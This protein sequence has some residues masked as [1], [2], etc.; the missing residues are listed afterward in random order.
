MKERTKRKSVFL[1][2]CL[3]LLIM[4]AM[5]LTACNTKSVDNSTANGDTQGKNESVQN[6]DDSSSDGTTDDATQ[7]EDENVTDDAT[8][9]EESEESG[10]GTTDKD[11]NP[12]EE[13]TD[14]NVT[15][16]D[17]TTVGGDDGETTD[18]EK[19]TD[20]TTEK[21]TDTKE[22]PESTT[23][24]NSGPNKDDINTSG[25]GQAF[26]TAE[27]VSDGAILH[28]W[29]WSYNDIR[30]HM[31]E[32]AQAGF[33]GIQTSPVQQP[34]DYTYEGVVYDTV[35]TPNGTGGNDGQ[36]WKLYQPVTFN[37]CNNGQTWLGTKEEFTL[38]CKEADKYG[39]KVIV[40]IVA[41]HMGNITG[42]KNS[43]SDITPQVGTYWN[44]EMLKDP[45]YW[46]IN[47]YQCWMSDGRMHL[48]MG[49]IGMPDLNTADKRVQKMVLD[50]LKE[51][52]DCGADGFRF[53]A[54][55]HI[56]TPN[57]S[58]S[59][60]SDFWPVVIDGI[61]DYA[62][63]ELFIYGEI[64]NTAGDNFSIKNYTNFM[65]VTD[66]ATGDNRRNDIRYQNAGSAS[67]SGYSY[68]A[69]KC[70]V[71]N[72]SHDTYVGAGSSYLANDTMIKQ[73][74]AV[75]AARKES[76]VLFFA[77]P[78]YSEQL[79][80]DNG[81]K[82]STHDLVQTIMGDV[83]TMTWSDP[84]VAAVNNF[85]NAFIG[86]T[87]SIYSNGS[88]ICIERGNSGIV[89]VNLKGAGSV[90]MS[91]KSMKD[92]TYTDRVTGNTF[93]VSGG[94]IKGKIDSKDGIAVIYNTNT[95]PY[96]DVSI[97]GG[98]FT[99]DS[100]VV[101]I[102][103]ENAVSGTYQIDNGKKVS[104]NKT[105]DV[106]IGEGVEYGQ[107][108]IL[109]I[110]ATDKNNVTYVYKHEYN[111]NRHEDDSV[112]FDENSG[113]YVIYMKNTAG[114]DD[115]YCYMWVDGNTN[116]KGWP[117]VKMTKLDATTYVYATD[118]EFPNIIF[119]NGSGTQTSDMVWPGNGQIYDNGKNKWETK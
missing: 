110:T 99:M 88:M 116:N 61:R 100:A 66:S 82:K 58:S 27:D 25:S 35:G 114:W 21:E 98:T 1:R 19:T 81:D 67:N 24:P 106:T 23:K 40:D 63:H 54:A 102:N 39:V 56:E 7:S 79:L 5:M 26:N 115:V 37:I 29:N 49:T 46:H 91:V 109:T 112:K 44:Q 12:D 10:E 87:E 90:S 77:R 107:S 43:M 4:S 14:E 28:C 48:T 86:Q 50:L 3:V 78:Y 2:R 51:C 69:S 95:V 34:K 42:W 62:D 72:E 65:S 52:V 6:Q 119:N 31:E 74:W 55:K 30:F 105:A 83:G 104:F 13:T 59:I 9:G 89:I 64:L 117:G 45:S 16:D 84:S 108:T 71:W 32:I 53:D 57:D 111:K 93:T 92:G 15:T 80:N 8:D 118:E 20:D 33:S 97:Q 76:T 75:L 73:T 18:S 101:K 11:E 68:E 113:K 85:R 60:A 38:M 36:W 41:N 17:E 96:A 47:N 70:V 94:T 22:E 103:L